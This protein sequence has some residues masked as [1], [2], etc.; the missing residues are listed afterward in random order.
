M[1]AMSMTRRVLAGGFAFALVLGV[2]GRRYMTT[3]GAPETPIV[4]ADET[5]RDA[6]AS[7]PPAVPPSAVAPSRVAIWASPAMR[8]AEHEKILLSRRLDR[9]SARMQA[10]SRALSAEASR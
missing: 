3:S 6:V 10:K 7:L 1:K 9:V 5:L 4:E 2:A 8:R